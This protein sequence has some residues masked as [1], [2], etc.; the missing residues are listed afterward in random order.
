MDEFVEAYKLADRILDRP[1]A[2]PD[3]DIAVLARQFQ[4]AVEKIGICTTRGP[5]QEEK[6]RWALMAREAIES[7]L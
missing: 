1:N 2:D 5:T 7:V 6:Q 3:G 4:R